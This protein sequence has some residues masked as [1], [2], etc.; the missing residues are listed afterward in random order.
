MSDPSRLIGFDAAQDVTRILGIAKAAGV[1]FIGRYLS[2]NA[3]KNLTASEAKAILG[4][5]LDIVSIWEAAGDQPATFNSANGIREGMAALVQAKECGQPSNTCIYFAVDLDA[6]LGIIPYIVSYFEAVNAV[7]ASHY[8]VGVYGSGLVCSQLDAAGLVSYDWLAGAMGWRG[9]RD[10]A[11]AHL[12]EIE[13]GWAGDPWGFGFDVDQNTA[14]AGH[15]FGSWLSVGLPS[16]APAPA[17][18]PQV[19]I[20]AMIIALQRALNDQISANLAVDGNFG[21]RS[22]A[23]L[24]RWQSQRN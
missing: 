20:H 24:Q 11:G 6:T 16:P 22:Y 17:P 3:R 19:D 8:K 13:Q 1:K 14:P 4:A 10:Y 23:A 9:S 15:D 7:L 21:P 2:F 18:V 12:S 5:G